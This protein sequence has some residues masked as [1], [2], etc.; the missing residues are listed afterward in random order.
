M[1]FQLNIIILAIFAYLC[2]SIPFGLIVSKLVQGIDIRKHGSQNI[3][4]TNVARTLGKKWGAI[5][6]LLDGSKALIPVLVSKIVSNDC[7][8][9]VATTTFF[10]VIGHIF[11]VWLGFKGG[12]G[13]ACILFSLFVIDYKLGLLFLLTWIVMFKLFKISALSA[14]TAM[15]ITTIASIFV[16]KYYFILMLLLS[17]ITFYK[18]KSNIKRILNGEELAFKKEKEKEKQTKEIKSSK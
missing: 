3:G 7:E 4:S 17:A 1:T 10:A 9:I 15:L 2:G 14:L 6:L 12:K 8:L 5:V 16:S 18:H 13:I 11:P